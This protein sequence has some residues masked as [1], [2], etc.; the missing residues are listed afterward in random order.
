MKGDLKKS[1]KNSSRW[2]IANLRS[3]EEETTGSSTSQWPRPSLITTLMTTQSLMTRWNQVTKGRRLMIWTHRRTLIGSWS[4]KKLS[5]MIFKCIVRTRD[6]RKTSWKWMMF[7][8]C[9][10]DIRSRLRTL[11]SQMPVLLSKEFN[12][13][14]LTQSLNLYLRRLISVYIRR[15][16][17]NNQTTTSL[18]KVYL[19]KT[20]SKMIE[21][22]NN[23]KTMMSTSTPEKHKFALQQTRK[24]EESKK[25]KT[26]TRSKCLR[27]IYTI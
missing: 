10:M 2:K 14:S 6:W 19:Q 12:S 17:H 16:W 4:T 8:W 26:S 1:T 24:I 15:S 21:F 20:C 3:E 7:V 18:E 5:L 25:S 9:L 22:I 23:W 27:M 13:H 11:N